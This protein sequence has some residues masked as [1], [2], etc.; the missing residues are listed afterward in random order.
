VAY[1]KQFVSTDQT[2]KD[3]VLGWGALDLDA[4]VR[5]L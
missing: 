3:N 5:S 2:G 4:V 1:L